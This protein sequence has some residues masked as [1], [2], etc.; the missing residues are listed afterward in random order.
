MSEEGRINIAGQLM[1]A[2]KH[3]EGAS[4]AIRNGT[5][6]EAEYK[7]LIR[8]L[9]CAKEEIKAAQGWTVLQHYREQ[10]NG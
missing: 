9:G 6:S 2:I 3:L 1:R 7:S 8:H 10:A 4:E 5:M